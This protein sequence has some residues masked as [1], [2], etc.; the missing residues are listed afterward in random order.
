[1]KKMMMKRMFGVLIG[2]LVVVWQAIAAES[3]SVESWLQ[4]FE[5]EKGKERLQIA[6]QL[7]E[8]YYQE[9]L[10][11]GLL[12]FDAKIH[13]DTLSQ[14]I[15]YWSAEY[16]YAVQNFQQ[17]LVYG[18]KALPLCEGTD[19]E[20]NCLSLMSLICFRL[21]NYQQAAEYAKRCYRIDERTGD[22]DIM[23]SSLNTLAGIYIGANQPKEAE[24]YILKG[25]ELSKKADNPARM[26]VLL[27]MASEVYHALGNDAEALRY[28]DEACQVEKSLK[29]E[30]KLM[31]RL[32]QKA[33]VL[34][35]MHQYQEA[36][37]ILSEVIP[38]LREKGNRHSLGI[39]CN[40][41]GMTLL[42]QER[43][44]DAVPYYRE[45]AAIFVAMGDIYNE[46]HSRRGLY[47]S[48]WNHHPDSAKMELDRFNELKDSLY[49]NAT[50]ESMAR[51]NAEFGTD[52]LRIE[53]E[54]Q[55]TR[56]RRA[57]LI[58][59]AGAILLAAGIWWLMWRKLKMRE[60][61]LQTTI[62]KLQESEVGVSEE[63]KEAENLETLNAADRNFLGQLVLLVMRG[64]PTGNLSMEWLASEMCISRGQLNRRVKAVTGITLQQYVMRVRMEYARLL[65]KQS[66]DVSIFDISCRCGFEDAA[67]FSRAFRRTYDQSP[68][69]YREELLK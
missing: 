31:V 12:R 1:M 29:R 5:K 21:S 52:Q 42:S 27:G 36:E 2:C 39:A 41:M 60:A 26:A 66:P 63:G 8:K 18:K 33:S 62:E 22:P 37:R 64:M 45:A 14:Q 24:N 54:I 4:Q 51:Y 59:L 16:F 67:S 65:M 3:K 56:T 32:A 13:S 28:I 40:K 68:T 19:V 57:I 9:E 6:N 48:L 23:S 25:I 17:A 15:W 10:T 11:D 44:M 43:E 53:N 34:I 50:A 30:D 46:M 69:Q 58:G 47:E 20:A 38:F 61:A 35:G 7:M 55:R 49:S